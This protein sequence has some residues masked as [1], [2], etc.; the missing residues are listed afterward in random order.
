MSIASI[1][2]RLAE[3]TPG[4]WEFDVAF[5]DGDDPGAE[6][7]GDYWT[8]CLFRAEEDGPLG[9]TEWDDPTPD[10]DLIAHAPTDLALLLDVAEAASRVGVH[11]WH[12]LA[13]A[14]DR[15]REAP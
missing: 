5:N 2:S 3:A 6:N 10:V 13:L 4:P 11:P 1:R 8:W 9:G 15:L 7:G 14:L 12:D